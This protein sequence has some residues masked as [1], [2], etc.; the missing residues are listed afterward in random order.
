MVLLM[1]SSEYG[2]ANLLL[3]ITYELLQC[4]N[5]DIHMASFSP[6]ESRVCDLQERTTQT[7]KATGST[8][9][10]QSL[11]RTKTLTSFA[12]RP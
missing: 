10:F 9:T 4:P 7:S 11:V 8:L 3:A 6:P 1:T 5:L 12:H 2:Q